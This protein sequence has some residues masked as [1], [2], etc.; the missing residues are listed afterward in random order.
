M[1]ITGRSG[2]ALAGSSIMG[3]NVP[4]CIQSG[5]DM[6]TKLSGLTNTQTSYMPLS[7]LPLHDHILDSLYDYFL[8]FC[9]VNIGISSCYSLSN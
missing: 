6:S 9:F 4:P 1:S 2:Q 5:I 7:L 3:G 8:Y